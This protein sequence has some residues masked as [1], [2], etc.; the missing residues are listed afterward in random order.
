M[1]NKV[2]L[3]LHNLVYE[4]K[5]TPSAFEE[6]DDGSRVARQ[7]EAVQKAAEREEGGAGERDH[8]CSCHLAGASLIFN[9]P[10]THKNLC[11]GSSQPSNFWIT[12]RK[13]LQYAQRSLTAKNRR[14]SSPLNSILQ[15]FSFFFVFYFL[16]PHAKRATCMLCVQR[17]VLCAKLTAYC[18]ASSSRSRHSCCVCRKPNPSHTPLRPLRHG[19]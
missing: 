14:T 3:E 17:A 8:N 1:R 12:G 16:R 18:G 19:G 13:T 11:C 4:P 5:C 6:V 7:P 2:Y 10:I 9:R 15:V